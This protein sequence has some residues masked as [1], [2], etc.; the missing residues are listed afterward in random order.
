MQQATINFTA[1]Q[2]HAR[3]SLADKVRGLYRS[4]NLW[5]DAKSAIYSRICE[6]SVTRRLVIRINLVSLCL[7]GAAIAIEQ[8]P[9]FSTIAIA[10]AGWI[11]YRINQT[12]K[13]QQSL[14][15]Q[16]RKG[17]KK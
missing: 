11:V 14:T 5:L 3:V 8:Q 4:V 13:N 6:F 7:M 9:L 10:C 1:Q 2:V 12:D 17:D 15:N 16:G